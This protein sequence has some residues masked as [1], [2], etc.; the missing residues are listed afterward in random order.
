MI[1]NFVFQTFTDVVA[2]YRSQQ[3]SATSL[4]NNLQPNGENKNMKTRRSR[5]VKSLL[6]EFMYEKQIG[7]TSTSGATKH[8]LVCTSTR[9]ST[10][11]RLLQKSL[12][13]KA[14][15]PTHFRRESLLNVYNSLTRR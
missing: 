15:F 10:K 6:S 9:L 13:R 1:I 8:Q 5:Q 11:V 2:T 4:P 12:Y 14:K 3:L 7:E